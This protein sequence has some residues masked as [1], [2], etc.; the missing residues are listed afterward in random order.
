MLHLCNG[1]S[2]REPSSRINST[3]LSLMMRSLHGI[4]LGGPCYSEGL[5]YLSVYLLLRCTVVLEALSSCGAANLFKGGKAT[6]L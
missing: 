5:L 2:P 4:G 6:S 3:D 1:Y